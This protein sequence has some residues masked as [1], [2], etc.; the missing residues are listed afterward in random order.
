MR[1]LYRL[2]GAVALAAAPV[3]LATPAAAAVEAGARNDGV[4]TF[5]AA[6][7]NKPLWFTDAGQPSE[8]ANALLRLLSTAS[9]DGLDASKYDLPGLQD[10]I[11]RAW[12]GDK[13]AVHKA[14]EKLSRAF[15]TYA[16]DLRSNPGEGLQYL[17]PSLRT[18][19]QSDLTFLT[20]AS[21]AQSLKAFVSDMVWMNPVYPKLRQ[22]LA[23]GSYGDKNA[24]L[25]VNLQRARVLPA[26]DPRYIVVNAAEQRLYMYENG[27][28][29]DTM[30]VVVGQSKDDRKTPVIA[31]ALRYAS[32]NPYWNVPPDLVWDDVG[33][34]VE[35]YGVSWMRERGFEVLSDWTD[36]AVPI[37]PETVD[38]A[39]VKAGTTQIRV[40]QNPG[41]RNVLGKV[42]YTFSNP[43]GVY[44]H[45]TSAKQ[46][47]SHDTRTYSGGCIRLEDAGRLGAWLFGRELQATSDAPDIKVQ[48]DKPI[49]VYVT[50][51]TAVPDGTS[52][53]F[54]N[55]VYDWDSRRLA[56]LGET[57]TG[58]SSGR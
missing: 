51:M 32:L 24:V 8:A 4:N 13:K 7:S 44:L 56:E 46:L 20:N 14:D 10:G 26:G 19:P 35:K 49:P 58:Q 27:H 28:V 36:N 55:D 37:D 33:I 17:D 39:A 34:Y 21:R 5:Y 41:P 9:L 1:H 52:V 38:W 31:G 40:R 54:H 42:K 16:R 43:F 6:R 45:D 48:M 12:G 11:Q 2:A 29:R 23:S 18:G 25:R 50:Y 47:L 15:T 53:T 22:A 3:C 57:G 30:R